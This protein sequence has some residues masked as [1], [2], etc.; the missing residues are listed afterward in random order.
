VE[1]DDEDDYV[2]D[3]YVRRPLS[4][5]EMLKNPLAE[6]ESDQ[7]QKNIANPQP[8]VG[9]IVITAEDEEYWEDFVEDDEEEWDSEDAD[10]NGMWFFPFF[11]PL[12]PQT[13][14]FPLT[15]FTTAENNPANDY[16]DEEASSEDDDFDFDDSA[17]EDGGTGYM[18]RYRG[19]VDSDEDY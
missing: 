15:F 11:R 12:H 2:Y 6:F 10:S 7:Q 4:D 18:S 1:E 17:S 14:D 13:I 19:H 8:G 16:P 9:V 5:A 3:V